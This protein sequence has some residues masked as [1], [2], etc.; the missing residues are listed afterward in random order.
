MR[1]LFILFLSISLICCSFLFACNGGGSSGCDNAGGDLPS[2]EETFDP[3]GGGEKETADYADG[4]SGLISDYSFDVS[5]ATEIL[6]IGSNGISSVEVDGNVLNS[7]EYN[8]LNNYLILPTRFYASLGVGDHT[9]KVTYKTKTFTFNFNITD[10]GDL[11]YDVSDF[12]NLV[13][14]ESAIELPKV[15]F[16][17]QGQRKEVVYT[18]RKTEFYDVSDNGE[19]NGFNCDGLGR[20]YYGVRISRDQNVVF[21]HE[22]P[23]TVLSD[24]VFNVYSNGL[25]SSDNFITKNGYADF[26]SIIGDYS[27]GDGGDWYNYSYQGAENAGGGWQFVTYKVKP[28]YFKLDMK[29]LKKCYDAGQRTVVTDYAWLGGGAGVVKMRPVYFDGTEY[30]D[31]KYLGFNDCECDPNSAKYQSL[32][33]AVQGAFTLTEEMFAGEDRYI[34]FEVA[35]TYAR[36]NLKSVK[37]IFSVNPEIRLFV[38]GKAP[39]AAVY[40]EWRNRVDNSLP[41]VGL[42]DDLNI[43]DYV[44]AV[45]PYGCVFD[46]ANPD[47]VLEN[48]IFDDTAV[49][50]AVNYTFVGETGNLLTSETKPDS[51]GAIITVL[52][53]KDIDNGA[54]GI[55][56]HDYYNYGY[57]NV[58]TAENPVY[59]YD[60]RSRLWGLDVAFDSEVLK[61]ASD[62][63]MNCI[64]VE[65]KYVGYEGSAPAARIAPNYFDGANNNAISG[66][67]FDVQT[68]LPQEP[69]V[70]YFAFTDEMATNENGF[71]SLKVICAGTRYYIYS[72]KFVAL[73]FTDENGVMVA[74]DIFDDIFD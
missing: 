43:T 12:V 24:S 22:F 29:T 8:V 14:A 62:M 23:F 11:I 63:G 66:V 1:K 26:I 25:V 38:D 60:F 73:Y 53:E 34:A 6:Y 35:Q 44:S 16:G 59:A 71:V 51:A 33:V 48:Y 31:I 18:V 9:V 42:F 52:G 10:N 19:T 7:A 20:Y 46:S 57:R 72:I 32:N 30:R 45:L 68:D 36:I 58:G 67:G 61:L 2:G 3:F 37:C 74:E 55:E 28:C 69:S 49:E 5:Q 47:N 70:G 17:N 64:V 13:F 4:D 39:S 65:Y 15:R 40:N 41:V 21:D 50:Y 56:Y 54:A 27:A